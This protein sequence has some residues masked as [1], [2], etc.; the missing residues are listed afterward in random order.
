MPQVQNH[1]LWARWP[2]PPTYDP[3]VLSQATHEKQCRDSFG[4]GDLGELAS[5]LLKP[6]LVVA[7]WLALVFVAGGICRCRPHSPL[8]GKILI[9][10][11]G[12]IG[13]QHP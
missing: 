2:A 12:Y 9:T 4:V 3:G 8:A 11:G 1:N 5:V 7:G 13:E 6:P 10:Q